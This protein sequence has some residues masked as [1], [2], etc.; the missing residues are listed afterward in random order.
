MKKFISIIICFALSIMYVNAQLSEKDKEY[1]NETIK[2]NNKELTI[3]FV[4]YGN[5][6]MKA[7]AKTKAINEIIQTFD[8][9]GYYLDSYRDGI[10]IFKASVSKQATLLIEEKNNKR[11]K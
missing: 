9:N 7:P 11:N 10:F 5:E 6:Y 8:R 3:A 4:Y 2:N 1:L